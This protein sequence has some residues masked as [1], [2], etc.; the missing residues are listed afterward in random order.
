MNRISVSTLSFLALIVGPTTAPSPGSKQ[1]D[2]EGRSSLMAQIDHELPD[3]DDTALAAQDGLVTLD[4]FD[5]YVE[6]FD[7]YQD[8]P[9]IVLLLSPT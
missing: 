3:P 2:L 9:R 7:A 1:P 8:V 6:S 5:Q 4:S